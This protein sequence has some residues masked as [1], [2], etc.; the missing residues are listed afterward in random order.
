MSLYGKEW[1]PNMHNQK[2]LSDFGL[3]KIK[4]IFT[5]DDEQGKWAKSTH[6]LV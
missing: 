5:C 3:N 4:W 1:L 2:Y 6:F